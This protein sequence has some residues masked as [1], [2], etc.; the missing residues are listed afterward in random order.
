LNWA[1]D[2]SRKGSAGFMARPL[3]FVA[4]PFLDRVIFEIR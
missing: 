2:V 1:N 4:R 3:L